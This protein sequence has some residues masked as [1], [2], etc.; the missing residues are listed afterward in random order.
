MEK[1]PD[2]SEDFTN[3]PIPSMSE[4]MK[5]QDA[6]ASTSAMPFAQPIIAASKS[7]AQK[8]RE[9]RQRITASRTPAPAQDTL[10]SNHSLFLLF[11]SSSYSQQNNTSCKKLNITHV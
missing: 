1:Q 3:E 5:V 11:L 4:P 10:Y 6:I 2:E 8:Q 9:Y 7:K